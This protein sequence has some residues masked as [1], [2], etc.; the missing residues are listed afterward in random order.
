MKTNRRGGFTLVE[1]MIVVTIIALLAAIAVPNFLRARD[2]AVAAKIVE[3]EFQGKAISAVSEYSQGQNSIVIK[4][5]GNDRKLHT[6]RVVNRQIVDLDGEPYKANP[7]Y[8]P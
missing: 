6:S 3:E 4:Y 2:R 8:N 5:T 7:K 1:I